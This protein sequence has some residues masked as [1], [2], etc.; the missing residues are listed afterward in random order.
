MYPGSPKPSTNSDQMNEISRCN[1][2]PNSPLKP[3]ISKNLRAISSFKPIERKQ[4]ST[5]QMF[6]SPF[7]TIHMEMH[8]LYK[9][10]VEDKK[11]GYHD[12]LVNKLYG[13]KQNEIDFYLPQI[14]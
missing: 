2:T 9:T 3:E 7:F 13:F 4:N 10:I 8:Y 12:Y 1:S 5:F 14:W 11:R 6:D